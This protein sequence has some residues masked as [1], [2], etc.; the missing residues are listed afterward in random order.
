[1][2]DS[3]GCAHFDA[4][5]AQAILDQMSHTDGGPA[6]NLLYNWT[7]SAIVISVDLDAVSKGGKL[8]AVWGTTSIAGKPLDRMALPFVKNTLLGVA[9]F[10]TDD[11]SG[12]RRGEF[13]AALPTTSARFIQDLQKT[14]AFQDSLD[15]QCGNQV[16]A[17]PKESPLRY[18]A[19]PPVSLT[20][21][22]RTSTCRLRPCSRSLQRRTRRA[23]ITPLQ[24]TRSPAGNGFGGSLGCVSGS[25]A[26]LCLAR[27][28]SR[29]DGFRGHHGNVRGAAGA[30]L[31]SF[32]FLPVPQAWLEGVFL[33]C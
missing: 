5:T 27:G 6:Q 2:V 28:I 23:S 12:V 17:E 25:T 30:A 3:A 1:M 33:G 11:A 8:L 18:R 19:L 10:S 24:R 29:D 21:F 7:V 13:D 31:A 14:L 20:V 26:D 4:A 16:L 15:G 32:T 9:P 22:T